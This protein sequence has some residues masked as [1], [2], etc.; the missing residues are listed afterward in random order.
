MRAVAPH[1]KRRVGKGVKRRAH[2]FTRRSSQPLLHVGIG[3]P[4]AFDV[5]DQQIGAT[6]GKRQREE[7]HPAD[8][9]GTSSSPYRLGG[10]GASRLYPPYNC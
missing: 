4:Q 5:T 2:A 6:V 3:A 8:D 7:E 9:S 10:H 1:S